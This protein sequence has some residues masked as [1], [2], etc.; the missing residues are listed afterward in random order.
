MRIKT[1]FGQ[2]VRKQKAVLCLP[3]GRAVKEKTEA[4]TEFYKDSVRSRHEPV[5]VTGVVDLTKATKKIRVQFYAKDVLY[6]SPE[7][8]RK[9]AKDVFYEGEKTRQEVTQNILNG[10]TDEHLV[11]NT[12]TEDTR[13]EPVCGTR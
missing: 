10:V 4:H 1:L 6:V 8:W 3:D 5:K 12:S 2:P 7:D 13:K 9:H 11:Q